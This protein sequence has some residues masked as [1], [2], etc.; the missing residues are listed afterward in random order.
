MESLLA[1]TQGLIERTYGTLT[2]VDDIAPFVVG[3]Q[4]Y[5]RLAD[6][7]EIVR[8]VEHLSRAPGPVARELPGPSVLIRSI[9][10]GTAVAVYFPDALISRLESDPPTRG[11]GPANVDDFAAF[12]E[13]IDHFIMIVHGLAHHREMSLLE[14]E[15]RANITKTLVVNHFVGRLSGRRSLD[16]EQRRW[17][18]YH[19]LDKHQFDEPDEAVRRRYEDARRHAVRVLDGLMGL[20]PAALI[21]VLRRWNALPAPLKLRHGL[22]GLL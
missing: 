8:A 15:I 12:I 7:H 18:R 17:I 2:G 11:V 9:E 5:R 3:D 21:D 19:L 10:D 14:L 4:G 13:E 1:V 22:D 20:D 16:A 6:R